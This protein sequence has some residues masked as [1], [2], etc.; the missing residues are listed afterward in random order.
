[1]ADPASDES[2]YE[3]E[4]KRYGFY[5]WHLLNSNVIKKVERGVL[6]LQ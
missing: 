4:A 1:V 6:Q 5:I 2:A 3:V